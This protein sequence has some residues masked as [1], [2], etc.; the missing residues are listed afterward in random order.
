MKRIK[1]AL[2]VLGILF[3]ASSLCFT[4]NAWAAFQGEI[5]VTDSQIQ[6]GGVE[7]WN[8]PV[9]LVDEGTPLEGVKL[10]IGEN[11]EFEFKLI[12]GLKMSDGSVS[13][14]PETFGMAVVGF[15]SANQGGS[16]IVDWWLFD[17][18]N[19]K[20]PT[21]TG[22]WTITHFPTQINETGDM[23][24]VMEEKELWGNPA[25][26]T[27][28]G[29]RLRNSSSEKGWEFH[30]VKFLLKD[31]EITADEISEEIPEP[32]TV[33]SFL[34]GGAGLAAKRLAKRKKA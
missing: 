29:G 34:L 30:A 16:A 3:V 8:S 17:E 2:M 10:G 27:G 26:I 5:N 20:I 23:S 14:D 31:D 21:A 19:Q 12:N 28:I 15:N 13:G 18:N 9:V 7:V 1:M 24:M 11:F 22:T 32:A 4:G 25:T 6:H 33:I